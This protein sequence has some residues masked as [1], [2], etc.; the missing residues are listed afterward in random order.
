MAASFYGPIRASM[1]ADAVISLK[2]GELTLEHLAE[3]LKRTG[4]QA[5]IRRGASDDPIAAVLAAHDTHGN[6]VDLL[7]GIRGMESAAFTR[8]VESQFMNEPIRLIGIEDFIAMKMFAGGP[9]DLEDA[10]NAVAVSGE[11]L[12]MTLLR[13]LT[14]NYGSQ[15]LKTL[16]QILA[17]P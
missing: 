3:E 4:L 1:D 2:S 11:H 13:K 15:E 9:K 10:K 7:S 14:H 6:R 17:H 5:E 16:E 8:A 12:D